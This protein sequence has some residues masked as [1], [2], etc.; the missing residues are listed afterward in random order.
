MVSP[1]LEVKIG[2]MA[3]HMELQNKSPTK[4]ILQ[5]A[6]LSCASCVSRVEKRLSHIPG[7]TNAT[8]NLASQKAV[9]EYLTDF[10]EPEG[11]KKIIEALGY[12]VL[13]TST[14]EEAEVP[15][16]QSWKSEYYQLR[17]KFVI[18][19][20]LGGGVMLISMANHS[21]SPAVFYTLFL[22]T[23]PVFFW[24]GAQFFVGAWKTLRQKTVDMNTLIVMGTSAAYLYS[25]I[26]TF[27][28]SLFT[29]AGQKLM[30][31]FDTT[32]MIIV[33]ILLGRM[34]ENRA[35]SKTTQA[36]VKL[37]GLRPKT[38]W[39]LREGQEL[40]VP[41]E[42]IKIGDLIMVKPGGKIPSDG[43]VTDGQSF[44]DES[45]L[46]GESLP[47]EKKVG[48]EVIGATINKLGSFKFRATKV[49]KDTTLAQIIRLVQEAQGSKAPI[50]RMA[51]LVSAYFVP[52]VI[53]IAI[54]T[55]FIWYFLGPTT[56]FSFALF[57]FIAVLI[58]ACPCA[59]GLAT[60]TAIMVGTGKG[61]EYGILIKGG[62]S[63]ET[64]HKIDTI[65]FDKT[66]TLTKGKPRVTDIYPLPGYEFDEI[67]KWAASAEKGSEHPL[68]RAI[69]ELAR[70][71]GID[72]DN[73][74]GLEAEPGYGLKAQI[75][76]QLVLLGNQ[77]FMEDQG[78]ILNG[79]EKQASIFSTQG[80]TPIFLALGQRGLGLL[81]VADTLK[82]GSMEAL[83][84]LKSLGLH[85]AM[86]TGDNVRTA[87][88]IAERLGITKVMAEVLPHEKTL[89]IKKLQAQGKTVAM[90]GDGINDA[91]ALTQAHV[92]IALGTGTDVAMESA[93]IILIKDDLVGIV[94]AIALSKR[95]MRTIK[96]NL[97]WAFSYNVIAIPVA[98]GALYPL[99]GILLNPM[100]AAG[101]MAFSSVSVVTNSLR[102][103]RL[104]L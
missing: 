54:L 30:V 36:I 51:D 26:A 64:L 59:M 12:Q 67:L 17:N 28:P 58:I 73:H 18:N 81:A 76:H 29:I 82:E 86:I 69:V 65:V 101:A 88:A 19:A 42:D 56:S 24:G 55:F 38:A 11:I 8:V 1:T 50:Q 31:Y 53:G 93:D 60:P 78:V 32:A 48:D 92:G 47:V 75:N 45:M 90:V 84:R 68:A 83:G 62:E 34:L 85:L 16:G 39:V 41:V 10:L 103:M 46:T 52:L 21:P 98:A 72:L 49:G 2:V 97:F 89:E 9:I 100:I 3:G 44:V 57:N 43:I 77:K 15:L 7:V 74:E 20:I 70:E 79:L 37:I 95:T 61:A 71:K 87:Q 35:K 91:P 33:L 96:Q 104:R 23:T 4:A 13:S 99:W 27:S 66:G 25:T 40:E 5:L 80:K 102:L 63:L 14:E 6:G 22:L 94:R